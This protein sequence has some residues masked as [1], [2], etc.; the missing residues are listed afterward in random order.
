MNF[1]KVFEDQLDHCYA[2]MHLQAQGRDFLVV[3]SEE[4]QPCYAYDLDHNYKRT[5]EDFRHCGESAGNPVYNFGVISDCV[6]SKFDNHCTDPAAPIACGD[7]TCKTDY[8]SCLRD[9]NLKREKG[10][11]LDKYI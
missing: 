10:T 4:D 2:V 7:G 8:I 9:M 11:L 6:S 5:V 1:T 3:A